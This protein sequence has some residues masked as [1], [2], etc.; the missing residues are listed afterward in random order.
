MPA[1]LE[2]H[3]DAERP[4]ETEPSPAQVH[5]L[6]CSILDRDDAAHQQQVKPW[7]AW[8]VDIGDPPTVA[9]W[10]L[11]WLP[12]HLAP[13]DGRLARGT[14]LRLGARYFRLRRVQVS[15]MSY[16]DLRSAASPT[17]GA[18]AG[19]ASAD[20]YF[21]SPTCFSRSD[22]FYPLPDPVLLF[23]TLASRWQLWNADPAAA[24]PADTLKQLLHAVSI[25]AHDVR[26]TRI[27]IGPGSRPGFLGWAR[28]ILTQ[29]VDAP[30][31]QLFTTLA[32]FAE[33]SGVGSATTHGLGAVSVELGVRQRLRDQADGRS[34]TAR[35]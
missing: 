34:S 16:P 26:T 12:D 32:R 28:Y 11:H 6:A 15:A 10:R 1:R 23:D 9:K 13:P 18:A 17:T 24:I 7:S 30:V 35:R 5:G 8:P 14:R 29:Q 33:Y 31:R 20:V 3:L 22:R 21:R 2:L 4:I 27:S 25:V 19:A